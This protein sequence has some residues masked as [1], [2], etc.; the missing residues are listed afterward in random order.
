MSVLVDRSVGGSSVND[1]EVEIML[2]RLLCFFFSFSF[3]SSCS[4]L[5]LR[6]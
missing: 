6:K 1:G 3:L 2:H 4:S 5:P